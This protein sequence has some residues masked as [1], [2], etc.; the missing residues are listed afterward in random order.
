M[1]NLIG[2]LIYSL[3]KRLKL[4]QNLKIMYCLTLSFPSNTLTIRCKIKISK[5]DCFFKK[6][7]NFAQIKRPFL[8]DKTTYYKTVKA[9]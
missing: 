3:F 5:S 7:R 1:I 9:C 6:N 8:Y 4:R 2:R